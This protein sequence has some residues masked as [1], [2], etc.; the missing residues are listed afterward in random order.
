MSLKILV[1]GDPHFKINNV[2]E[3]EMMVEKILFHAKQVKPDLI[4]NL[5]DTLDRHESIH[6]DPN[7]R[8][9][10]FMRELKNIAHTILIIGNHDRPNNSVF[11]TDEHP[12]I[13]MNEWRNLTVVDKVVVEH[14]KGYKIL[15]VP[16][17][18]VGRFKEALDSN[19][20]ALSPLPDIVFSHQEYKGAK[21][22]AI[23]SEHGDEWSLDMPY[24]ISG[25]VHDYDQLQE[26]LLYLG[27]PIQ[28]AFGDKDHKCILLVTLNP[29]K[30]ITMDKIYLDVANKIVLKVN[31]QEA[32]NIQSKIDELKKK[33]NEI[34]VVVEGTTT[35]ISSIIKREELKNLSQ[36][37]KLVYDD[38]T[39]KKNVTE[40]Q[41]IKDIHSHMKFLERLYKKIENNSSL[42]EAFKML[43]LE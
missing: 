31:V 36:G 5:G 2:R 18:P 14:H 1:I 8:A 6:V 41:T 19:P 42:V 4:V 20:E 21:M 24:N 30:N 12:F 3:T 39:N 7:Y 38:I 28:H 25:H 27:T 9:V 17:V 11:L 37:I 26:N 34:K 15:C 22:G 13:A 16:Y 33:G 35:E 29:D 43:E 10:N 23:V 32:V 40:E